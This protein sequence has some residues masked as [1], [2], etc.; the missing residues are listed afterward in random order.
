MP[1]PL[2]SQIESVSP[3]GR[4]FD[5]VNKW[6]R[7]TPDAQAIVANGQ[8]WTYAALAIAVDHTA[9][10]FM[11]AGVKR[12]DR[13]AMIAMACPEFMVSFMAAAKVGAS[14]LGINPKFSPR[15]IAYILGDCRP[16]LLIALEQYLGKPVAE[17]LPDIDLVSP[18]IVMTLVIG[19]PLAGWESYSDFTSQQRP[20]LDGDL[21]ERAIQVLPQDEALLMYTSGSTGKPKGVVQT[22]AS[23]LANVREQ[24]RYFQMDRETRALLHFPINHVAADVEIGFAT[25]YAGGTLVMMDRFDPASTLD[26]LSSERVTMLGQIPAM[27]LLQA[28][29]PKF[30]QADFSSLR[31]IIWGGA[32]AP[33]S[34]LTLLQKIAED[35]GAIL[36]TGYGSTEACGFVT[37]T[38][39]SDDLETLAT[40]VGRAPAGFEIRVVDEQRRPIATGQI[41]EVALRGP[42]LFKEYLN[43]PQATQDCTDTQGWFYTGD[44]G[45]ID[46][47]GQLFLSGRKS[48]MYKSGGENVFP[49]EIEEVLCSHPC[50]AMAA[51]IGVPDPLYQEVGH[52]I[53]ALRPGTQ[54]DIE[55]LK[56]HCS[57]NLVNFKVPKTLEIRANL[58]LLPNGKI[59]KVQLKR[60][61]LSTEP[62]Q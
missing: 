25:V 1:L 32:A 18:G 43:Q 12:G 54:A 30:D 52:A 49:Q 27:F 58:P 50:V 40:S 31:T 61:F 60:E 38:A 7:E 62:R 23:I 48:E 44:L 39:P 2:E 29:L 20:E 8:R 47:S 11:A 17:Q 21:E 57:H 5:F 51:V 28:S 34:L 4:L 53:V 26:I 41:G 13:V 10:A 37:Y 35:S 19:S 3:S 46:S 9:K 56:D 45:S 42:F 6:S 36:A 22:H 59:D 24:V 33:R 15:E 55:S 14:W 16:K